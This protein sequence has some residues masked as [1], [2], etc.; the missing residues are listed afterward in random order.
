[1]ANQIDSAFAHE[2][3]A[4]FFIWVVLNK[5][6]LNHEI[7]IKCIPALQNMVYILKYLHILYTSIIVLRNK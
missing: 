5:I 2:I 6:T 1:M 7:N 3:I 4:R